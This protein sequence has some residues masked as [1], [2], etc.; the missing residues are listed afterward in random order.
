MW[1]G[2]SVCAGVSIQLLHRVSMLRRADRFA[3]GS[4][5]LQNIKLQFQTDAD[6]NPIGFYSY[7]IRDSN[8]VVEECMLLSNMIVAH[9]CVLFCKQLALLR[10]H[11]PPNEQSMQ[12]VSQACAELGFE[13]DAS[14][15]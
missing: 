8:R 12:R 1:C 4:L 14:T 5:T 9:Q 10:R 11:P 13:I 6:K 3:S 7:I 15:A 2:L